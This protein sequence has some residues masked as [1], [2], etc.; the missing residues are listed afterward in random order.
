MAY[1]KLS[2]K[3]ASFIGTTASGSAVISNISVTN[4]VLDLQE[5]HLIKGPGIPEGARIL[6]VDSA[7]QITLN[8]NA[9]LSGNGVVLTALND[10]IVSKKAQGLYETV[11]INGVNFDGTSNI[12]VPG[13]ITSETE[14]TNPNDGDLW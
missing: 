9:I 7:T 1:T 3:I 11:T 5:G 13:S 12:V 8:L 2:I 4:S 14:P 6:S 10:D